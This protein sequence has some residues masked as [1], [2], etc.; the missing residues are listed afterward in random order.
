M[1]RISLFSLLFLPAFY[2]AAQG[3]IAWQ[4]DPLEYKTFVQNLGQFDKEVLFSHSS[5]GTTISLGAQSITIRMES[6]EVPAAALQRFRELEKKEDPSALQEMKAIMKN[7]VTRHATLKMEWVGSSEAAKIIPSEIDKEYF[8][9]GL[10][11]DRKVCKAPAFRKL[12]LKDI[13]P[14]TDLEYTV[15]EKGGIKYNLILHPGA[16]P[17]LIKM[18]YT[19]ALSLNKDAR[20]NIVIL[21]T[22]GESID[23]APQSFYEDGRPIASSFRL[24]DNVVSFQLQATNNK[25]TIIIDPWIQN[26][27]FP[28]MNK[29]YDVESDAAGNVYVYGNPYVLRKYDPSGTPLWTY[30]G[31]SGT[32]TGDLVTDKQGNSYVNNCSKQIHKVDAS[33]SPVWQNNNSSVNNIMD[34][35]FCLRLNVT[36]TA[37]IGTGANNVPRAARIDINTGAIT[38][39]TNIGTSS[40]TDEV[41]WAAVAPNG[42]YYGLSVRP[43]NSSTPSRLVGFTST[44]LSNIFD[45]QSG[46][47]QPG[48]NSTLN[49]WPKYAMG[50][51]G[52]NPIVTS[53]THIY[54]FD[55]YRLCKA[56]IT[57]GNFVALVTVGAGDEGKNSG[58]AIDSC[59]NLYVGTLTHIY[60]YDK[61]LNFL[62]SAPTPSDVYDVAIGPGNEIYAT[63]K[64]FVASISGLKQSCAQGGMV[65]NMSH[66]DATC[67]SNNGQASAVVVSGGIAPYTYSWSNGFTSFSVLGLSAGTYTVT[68]QDASCFSQLKTATVLILAKGN[69]AASITVNNQVSCNGGTNG[70]ASA[71]VSGVPGPYTYLWSPGGQTTQTATGLSAATY[72]VL[73]TDSAGCQATQTIAITQPGILNLGGTTV[74]ADCNVQNGSATANASGGTAAYT[75]IWFPGN[76]STATATGLSAGN[77]TVTVIDNNGCSRALAITVLSNPGPSANAGADQ[78]IFL[79]ASAALSAGGGATYSWSPPDGLSCTNCPGPNANPT[80]TTTYTVTVYDVNGCS[81][82]DEVTV[83]IECAELFVPN[84]FSP[85]GD[86]KNDQLNLLS[87]CVSSYVFRVF[88]RWGAKVFETDSFSK[89]WDGSFDGKKCPTAVFVWHAEAVLVT[90]QTVSK[91]GSVTLLR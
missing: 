16:D 48:W 65:V 83:T 68:I 76:Q 75:Y 77:Y 58:I 8:N 35:I 28:N 21:T 34:E 60:K 26:P 86:G 19:G 42:N 33:G 61:N 50:Y 53:C 11:G 69:G 52:E 73:I 5:N 47:T 89:S 1:R 82:S 55:G 3:R 7:P 17:S 67:G 49:Y 70:S 72:T 64:G 29:G 43:A 4:R 30:T 22:M 6:T 88:D 10:G 36:E 13:Y 71:T 18:K 85:N 87:N 15:H 56:D 41:R 14:G 80:V 84:V 9:Y 46:H 44:A 66:T 31:L 51:S 91:K 90:G 57:T 63:G 39:I 59:E 81:S 79:G 45:T 2:S 74:N 12:L 24:E 32:W 25:Q 38:A 37:L 27:A 54:T 62:G 23:H 20:G 40:S 78:T